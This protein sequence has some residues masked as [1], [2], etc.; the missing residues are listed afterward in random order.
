MQGTR[1]ERSS[2]DQ[3]SRVTRVRIRMDK[4]GFSAVVRCGRFLARSA[5]PL[6]LFYTSAVLKDHRLR[7]HVERDA[8]RWLPAPSSSNH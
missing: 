6:G 8:D 5:S 2:A 3:C 1:L 7:R 4:T